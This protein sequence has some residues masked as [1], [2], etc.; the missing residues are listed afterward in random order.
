M[1]LKATDRAMVIAPCWMDYPLY[2]ASLGIACDMVTC[3]PAKRLDLDAVATA[4]TPSTRALVLSQPA[5]PT[6]VLYDREELRQLGD[7]LDQLSARHGHRPLLVSDEVHRDQIWTGTPFSSPA[8]AYDDTLSVYSY[9]KAWQMQGQRIGYVAVS[10]RCQDREALGTALLEGAR[11]TGHCAPTTLMQH[12]VSALADH[13][14]ALDDLAQTQRA[15]REAL[16]AAGYEVIDGQAAAFIYVR[17]PDADAFRF[18]TALAANG[19]LAMPSTIFHEP[20]Y[21]RIALNVGR[22]DLDRATT[23]LARARQSAA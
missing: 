16:V 18:V 9:G 1:L 22:D 15:A 23:I 19:V 20:G 12:L 6:G 14:P 2:L 7:L 11:I 3:T 5:C 21:F 8:A 10:P 17:C 4:W 13:T